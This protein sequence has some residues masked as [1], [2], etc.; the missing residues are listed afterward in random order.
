MADFPF[1]AAELEEASLFLRRLLQIDT[2]NP[3][4]REREATAA[5]EA[6][7][8]RMGL[9]P[10]LTGASP[11]RPN[12][13]ARWEADPTNRT[14]RPLL[15]SCHLDVVPANP[16]DWTHP[17]FS[18]H[19][20]GDAI[21]GRG[22]IDMKGFAVMA[23]ASLARLRQEG[24]APTR[25]VI[26]VAAADEE[27]GTRLGSRWLVENR[28]DLLGKEP[29]YVINE[30]GGFTV[31]QKGRRFYP[32]Q[33]AEKGVAWIRLTATGRSG[34]SSLPAGDSSVAR[35]GSAIR[36]ISEA[37][38]PWH[39]SPEALRFIEGFARP[40][41]W[42]ARKVAPLLA[43]PRIGPRLL[44]LAVPE[45]SRRL[46]LEALLRNTANPTCLRSG[47]ATNVL[48][49]EV[50]VDIDGR[51]IPG[52]SGD[53]LIR[54]LKSV[55]PAGLLPHLRWEILHEAGASTFSTDTDLYRE[56]E[57]ALL[58]AD[59]DSHVVPSM[60]PGFTD[61][62]NYAKLGAQCYGF[63]PLQLPQELDFAALFHGVDER[64]PIAGFHWGI[65]TLTDMLRSFLTR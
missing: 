1:P 64:I 65:R 4:G 14:S 62:Q 48:P 58:E 23:L 26:F 57:R 56:M 25:D 55:L 63:Y 33:V 51:L 40:D 31:H 38:L 28:P 15:L 29:E 20:D 52:Q 22:A 12:L 50:S 60:I 46:S 44:P 59:P 5:V 13:T 53:D 19:D 49:D 35:L 41:T 21:W 32:I 7:C 36:A 61:S 54:E 30:V 3:P 10:V 9:D 24:I 39:P 37:Q 17:P 18:G 43:H 27:A 42:I 45:P 47:T 6:W 34:H 8:R 2:S 11:D 16:D